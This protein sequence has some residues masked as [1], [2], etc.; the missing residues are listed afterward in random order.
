MIKNLRETK[1]RL[2]QL[3]EVAARGEEVVIT[4]HGKPRARLT[5]V[6]R[7]PRDMAGWTRRLAALQRRWAAR[8]KPSSGASVLEELRRERT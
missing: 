3:V 7:A 4:V 5:G 6:L 8:A 2:S 1:A